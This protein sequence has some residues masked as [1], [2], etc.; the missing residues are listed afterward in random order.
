M[1][2]AQLHPAQASLQSLEGHAD[3]NRVM[4]SW[5]SVGQASGTS[6]DAIPRSDRS[7]WQASHSL[8]SLPGAA[9]GVN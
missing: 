5:N 7:P 4:Y 8:R 6:Q 9:G 2:Q 3:H 1:L